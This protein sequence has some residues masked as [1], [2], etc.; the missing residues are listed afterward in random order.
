M[1]GR[2]LV[3]VPLV[4]VVCGVLVALVLAQGNARSNA[5]PLPVA[6]ARS[7]GRRWS[8]GGVLA[9]LALVALLVTVGFAGSDPGLVLAAPLAGAALHAAIALTGEAR[10]PRPTGRVRSAGV[11]ARSVRQSAPPVLAVAAALG[12]LLL[13]A[14]CVGGIVVA[15]P[16]TDQ[17]VWRTWN[18]SASYGQF[19][20][21]AIGFP[22]LTTGLVAGWATLLVLL[23]IPDRPAVPCAQPEVDAALRRAAGHRVLRVTGSALL[24]TAGVLVVL[25]HGFVLRYGSGA[26]AAGVQFDG[27]LA[28][29][30]GATVTTGF[31]LVLLG[32]LTL[33]VPARGLRLPAAAPAPVAGTR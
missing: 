12:G 16:W 18:Y 10:W 8:A 21:G 20:G 33:V 22:V 6:A 31:V 25:W 5:L 28:A 11:T 27:P 19:P 26:T 9:G 2:L 4:L 1:S 17:Y 13:L 15:G 14:T 3:L 7:R 29:F 30:D 24:G 32:L 23:R